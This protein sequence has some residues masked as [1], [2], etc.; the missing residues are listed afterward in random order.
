MCS[1]HGDASN[2]GDGDA[3]VAVSERFE[4]GGLDLPPCEAAAQAV[5]AYLERGNRLGAAALNIAL[6]RCVVAAAAF[7]RLRSTTAAGC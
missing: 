2:R 7:A 4:G 1:Q 5:H 3:L 6:E